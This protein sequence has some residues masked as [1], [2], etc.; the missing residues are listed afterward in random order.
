[1]SK[2][3][4]VGKAVA[5]AA[6]GA[7]AIPRI[8]VSIK[9]GDLARIRSEPCIIV[10]VPSAEDQ[11]FISIGSSGHTI[12]HLQRDISYVFPEWAH[13]KKP[14]EPVVPTTKTR[15]PV[16]LNAESNA[17]LE[18]SNIPVTILSHLSRFDD[19]VDQTI[20]DKT[21]K[22]STVYKHFKT[23]EK[24]DSVSV[25]EVA[26]WVFL[27]LEGGA[28]LLS[29][30]EGTNTTTISDILQ[31]GLSPSE[32][33]ATHV[34]LSRNTKLFI[35]DSAPTGK[36]VEF[37][38]RFRLRDEGGVSEI[39]WLERQA[40]G[41]RP[42]KELT[43]FLEKAKVLIEWAASHPSVESSR[44]VTEGSQQSKPVIEFTQS[45]LVFIRAI[46]SAAFNPASL[47]NPNP[48]TDLVNRGILSRLPHGYSRK[49]LSRGF[50]MGPQASGRGLDAF[51]LLKDLGVLTHWENPA[52]LSAKTEGGSLDAIDGHS[53]S[54]WADLAVVESNG[55]ANELLA[56]PTFYN[57][58]T[59]IQD[60]QQVSLTKEKMTVTSETL[61]QPTESVLAKVIRDRTVFPHAEMQDT[62]PTRDAFE[63]TRR[64]FGDLPVYVIDSPTA[65]ELDDGISVEET[66]E[67]TWIHT[68]IADPTAY[69][70][71]N[72]PLSSLAQLRGVS[73]YLP[74]RHYP[75][76]PDVL[77]NARFNL[78]KSH[79]ALTFSCRLGS[80]GEIA[81]YKVTPSIIKN[82][83]ILH[84]RTVNQVL[85]WST[86]FGVSLAPEARSIWVS[87]ALT[88][89][90]PTTET[91]KE[92]LSNLD[93]K[94]I[95]DLKKL[96]AL[97][98]S[99]MKLRVSRGGFTSDQP[100]YG[101]KVVPYPLPITP[102]S[103]SKA[104]EYESTQQK[105]PLVLLDPNQSSHVEPSSNMVSECMIIANRIASK[106]CTDRSIPAL[107][108][109]Q[110]PLKSP[111]TTYQEG[112]I[113]QALD[114]ID[115]V[116]GVMPYSTFRTLL[117]FYSPGSMSMTPVAHF[118]LGIR[119]GS[120][121]PSDFGGYMKVTSPL[122]RFKDMMM[123]WLMKEHLLTG[124][125]RLFDSQDVAAIS[126]RVY[127]IE[128]RTQR[129]SSASSK[130][131]ALEWILRREV[132]WRMGASEKV[133]FSG[134]ALDD[135][136]WK[137]VGIGMPGMGVGP[138]G[139]VVWSSDYRGSIEWSGDNGKWE[140]GLSQRCMQPTY[141][142]V[143]ESVITSTVARGILGDLGGIGARIDLKTNHMVGDVIICTVTTVDPAAGVL[144]VKEQ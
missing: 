10:K 55:W 47:T 14:A 97:A 131:W 46:K 16:G 52:L 63:S 66:S 25:F 125:T 48:I 42:G 13:R 41:M 21:A 74:E 7:E 39:L 4:A 110:E 57:E 73:M 51:R 108:R 126:S 119:A 101:V 107:Y 62:F 36:L 104:F 27:G 60:E 44:Q 40:K 76:M 82:V 132:L 106:F 86:V 120:T 70:P 64:D 23:V 6:A 32:L 113:Q 117:P 56:S 33:Y 43:E 136:K 142:F 103:P 94:S 135:D 118:S 98:Y 53:F 50:N 75:M 122:R 140:V 89:H 141:R 58:L 20:H 128:K 109:G 17:L 65:Q 144:I 11:S 93:E 78:G 28:L 127:E 5:A 100:D 111:E 81:D 59:E 68:H 30:N 61:S 124:T 8:G 22:F 35:Q 49:V 9:V 138:R 29:G 84:Y 90:Q 92:T 37:N 112:L 18:S 69:L 88:E 96:Q 72:H 24:Q 87:K 34:Y 67:G 115:S 31:S 130:F 79:C 95:S 3:Q 54:E 91:A 139:P 2:A 83:K 133:V 12:R 15:T 26:K 19:A 77:S 143:L 121:A 134:V 99:H 71:P 1:M 114:S 137:G 123:H 38:A 116:S 45:D 102:N 80:D 129:V 105:P 85:D